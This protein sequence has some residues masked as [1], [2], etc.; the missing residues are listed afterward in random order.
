MASGRSSGSAG[1][2]EGVHTLAVAATVHE[3]RTATAAWLDRQLAAGTKVFHTVR[4]DDWPGG[5]RGWLTAPGGPTRAAA[6]LAAGQL[7]VMDF[8]EVLRVA[9]GTLEGLRTLQDA[10][11]ERWLA[12]GWTRIALSQESPGRAMRTAAAIAAYTAQEGAYDEL[13]RRAPVIT[14]CQLTAALENR[15]ASWESAALHCGGIVDGHWRARWV[16]ERWELAGEIDVHVAA[17]FGAALHGALRRRFDGPGGPDL[18]VDVSRVVF[19]DLASA[20]SL[21]LATQAAARHQTVV[22]HGASPHLRELVAAVGVPPTLR[23]EP[24]GP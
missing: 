14:R 7:E 9:G 22:V 19:F 16:H 21:L 24:D 20:Q 6:A 10:A 17:A 15:T 18:H 4:P 2:G 12:E 23:F 1:P 5:G 11:I 3:Q 8:T 13:G